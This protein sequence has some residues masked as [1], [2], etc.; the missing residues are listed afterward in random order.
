MKL[1][2]KSGV[3]FEASLLGW[4]AQDMGGGFY[5]YDSEPEECDT[6]FHNNYD[7]LRLWEL[8]GFFSDWRS[9]KM[10][11]IDFVRQYET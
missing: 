6:K 5:H 9:S 7:H 8:D 11:L 3:E 10:L 4:V 1:R 2:N